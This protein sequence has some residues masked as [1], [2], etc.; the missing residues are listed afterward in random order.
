MTEYDL[1]KASKKI[2]FGIA[3]R[4][5]IFLHMKLEHTFL[6]LNGVTAEE[7]FVSLAIFLRG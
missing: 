1:L 2:F 3:H 4:P 6:Y 7:L 5:I